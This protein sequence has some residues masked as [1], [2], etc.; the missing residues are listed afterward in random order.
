MEHVQGLSEGS[1]QKGCT[2]HTE[3]EEEAVEII[4]V[5]E[6]GDLG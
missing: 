4:Q 1:D 5:R 6:A 2:G 3:V